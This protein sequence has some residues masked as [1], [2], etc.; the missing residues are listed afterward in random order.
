[1]KLIIEARVECT[2][3]ELRRQSVRSLSFWHW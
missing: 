1:M 3:S 2:D